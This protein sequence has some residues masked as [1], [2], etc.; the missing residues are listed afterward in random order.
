M[1]QERIRKEYDHLSRS[2]RRLADFIVS[3]YHAAAFMTAA[4]LAHAVEVDT[5]TVVRFAQRLGY[6]GFPE[7]LADIQEQVKAELG[8][9][10]L[11]P[12]DQDTLQAAVQ[13]TIMSDRNNLGAALAYNTLQTIEAILQHLRVAR[14]IIV[15]GESYAAPL[16]E[17]FAGMLRDADLPALYVGGDIYERAAAAA[18]LL[19]K[20][21]VIGLTPLQGPSGVATLLRFARDEGAITVACT[22]SLTSQAACSAEY[23]LYAPG[24]GGAV[25]PSLTALY[26]LCTAMAQALAGERREAIRARLAEVNRALTE[27]TAGIA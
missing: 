1:F 23:L 11:A 7:L 19:S 16:A 24:D 17:S 15:A 10:Y 8:Q 3:N 2:Y 13:R 21:V 12:A 4:G 14:R 22:P 20:D 26:S 6:P 25:L 27:L 18:R 9:H 5:T